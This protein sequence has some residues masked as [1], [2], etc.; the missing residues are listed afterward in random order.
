MREIYDDRPRQCPECREPFPGFREYW[1]HAEDVHDY[2]WVDGKLRPRDSQ[3]IGMGRSALY[4]LGIWPTRRVHRATVRAL[5]SLNRGNGS[6]SKQQF[7]KTLVKAEREG[8]LVR[9]GDYIDILDRRAVYTRAVD[10]IE[11]P[12]HEKFLA[13]RSAIP[14]I[15][16]QMVAERDAVKRQERARELAFIRSLMRRYPGPMT[17]SRRPVR[18]VAAGRPS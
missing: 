17:G 13:L 14:V 9:S 3:Q 5:A 18:V 4:V 2:Q 11:S 15:T 12:T 16:A 6:Q 1:T 10:Q 8:L 7:G